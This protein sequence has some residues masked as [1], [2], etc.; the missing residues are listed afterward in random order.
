[1]V[2]CMP[3][4]LRRFCCFA[5]LICLLLLMPFASAQSLWPSASQWRQL[6]QGMNSD[7]T[8][9]PVM[10]AQRRIADAALTAP[11]QP[12]AT[13]SSGGRLQ[14]DAVKENTAASLKDM[15]KIQAL[16]LLYKLS[17]DT[18]YAT[19]AGDFLQAWADTNQP[20]G[21]PI[22]ETGLEPAIFGYR[23]V[24]ADLPE[25][26]R[27]R[28]DNWLRNVARAEISTR[29]MKRPTATNN[30]HSHR[31]KIVGLIGYAL[32]DAELI[33]YAKQG[34][35]T[36]I[37]DNLRADGE[38]IDFIE[39]D[40]LSYHVYDLRPL[41]TLTLAFAEDGD[42]LYRWQAPNGASVARSVAWL[43][44]YL[45][46]EKSHAE[47]AGSRVPFDKARSD[48]REKG[49]EIGAPYDPKNALPLMEL[50]AAY[51]PACAQLAQQ[52]GNGPRLRLLLSSLPK[53]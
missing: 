33:R 22:D 9:R 42:Q 46:G 43:L 51:D 21:Q 41:V 20:T 3:A 52:L 44:P 16:A 32:G 11:P 15:D 48:N 1:M 49:H 24:R 23:L 30:W 31:L 25:P 18:R 10:A 13:L 47:F 27:T 53:D 7:A 6:Q 28:I 34:F 19:R 50:A 26:R 12:I 8:V 5:S 36:Q 40:A 4:Y 17:G 38:S 45:R 2:M 35:L 37:A 14:G 39:R 29:V